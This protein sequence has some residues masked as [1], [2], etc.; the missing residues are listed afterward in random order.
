MQ[1]ALR[2]S[3]SAPSS[4]GDDSSSVPHSLEELRGRCQPSLFRKQHPPPRSPLGS[5]APAPLLA[6]GLPSPQGPTTTAPLHKNLPSPP[7]RHQAPCAP[8]CS[9][10]PQ[11]HLSSP[12]PFCPHQLLKPASTPRL[13][14][15]LFQTLPTPPAQCPGAPSPQRLLPGLQYP[16]PN[17][18]GHPAW[19][20]P[21]SPRPRSPTR[22]ALPRP[23]A[24]CADW[25]ASSNGGLKAE[26]RLRTP[27]SQVPQGEWM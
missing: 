9:G 17:P 12:P 16:H 11:P 20:C 7:M 27:W 26:S 22:M 23:Q 15:T 4:S 8:P 5:S 6:P 13:F 10:S 18:L 3:L 21:C 24:L 25:L 19:L 1:R 14:Q 2:V